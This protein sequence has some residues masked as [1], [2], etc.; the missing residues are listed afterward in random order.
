MFDDFYKNFF[1]VKQL[2]M[3]YFIRE[4]FLQSVVEIVKPYKIKKPLKFKF[5]TKLFK[6]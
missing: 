1:F 5:Y 4:I 6:S 3:L 2:I